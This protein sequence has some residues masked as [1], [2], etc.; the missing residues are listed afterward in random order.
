MDVK[1]HY[2]SHLGN[3]YS[4]MIGDFEKAAGG[5]A[6]FF[7]SLSIVPD[8]KTAF[9]LGCGSGV[10]S[11]ALARTGFSVVAI[12]FNRQ[13]LDELESR[14]GSLPITVVEA[15]IEHFDRAAAGRKADLVV[16]M[17]DTVTHLPS[18]DSVRALISTCCE[19]LN[20]GGT[21]VFSFRDLSVPLE[22]D[23]RFLPVKSDDTRILTCFLEY[24]PGYAV[25]HDLLHEK[26]DGAWVQKVSS[27]RKLRIPENEMR[28][29][30]EDGGFDVTGSQTISRMFY[31]TAK[32]V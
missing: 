18:I 22:G 17:G 27:Y 3:F 2:D 26:K 19:V 13:L 4:W 15:D 8:G 6:D 14:K 16:C 28:R 12:D 20:P 1:Q 31:M 9:D 21:I 11:V 5:Q 30:L 7:R 29:M 25:V 10:Q 24:F 23:S 32:R